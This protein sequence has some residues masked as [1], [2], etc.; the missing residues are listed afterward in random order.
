MPCSSSSSRIWSAR[1][2]FAR[3]LAAVAL[4]DQG[5]DLGIASSRRAFAVG[6]STSKIESKAPG[7]RAPR[8]TL[9][10]A[11]LARV[12]GGVGVAHVLEDGGQRFGGVQI[13][14]QAGR[15]TLAARLAVRA[16]MRVVQSLGE[17]RPSSGAA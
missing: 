10:G 2:K 6:C 14:V 1:A 12:H 7:M 8:P 11:E 17:L 9:P 13:V 4:G 5:V 16:A 3:F 15:R